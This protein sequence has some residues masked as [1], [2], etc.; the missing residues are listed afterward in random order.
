MKHPKVLIIG[1]D[2]LLGKA[3]AEHYATCGRPALF[4]TRK[5]NNPREGS[6]FLDILTPEDFVVPEGVSYAFLVAYASKYHECEN[7]PQA[8]RLNIE[9]IP[10]LAERLLHAG[11][12][13]NFISTNTL[14]GGEQAWPDEEAPHD[15]QIAY[16]QHKHETELRLTAIAERLNCRGKLAITRFTKILT[17]NTSPLPQWIDAWRKGETVTP[18]S[19]LIFSPVSSRFGAGALERIAASGH[20]GS[21]HVSG[22]ANVSYADFA[23]ELAARLGISRSLVLP[24]SSKEAGVTLYF[25]PQFSGLG[26]QRTT[27]LTG[28]TPQPLEAVLLELASGPGAD[29][30]PGAPL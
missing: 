19:D 24:G 11:I 21:F 16:A 18:F 29:L 17:N 5:K 25:A 6:I 7:N 20:A 2:S 23:L 12:F 28:I 4:T 3:L 13:V 22:A 27:A 8:E 30:R 10:A 1:G 9:A 26:M 15:P 14:F